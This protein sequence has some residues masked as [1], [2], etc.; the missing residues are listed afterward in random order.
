V[1]YA[2][3]TRFTQRETGHVSHAI[4]AT[5]ASTI[6]VTLKIYR[7][8]ARFSLRVRYANCF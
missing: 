6:V 7:A 8:G 2:I 5:T 4:I 1:N 3:A